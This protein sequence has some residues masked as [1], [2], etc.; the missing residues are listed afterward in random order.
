M[1]KLKKYEEQNYEINELGHGIINL[2]Q[3]LDDFIY[4]VKN[5]TI[6]ISRWTRSILSG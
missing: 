5:E 4:W 3:Q 2:K 6:W 1:K